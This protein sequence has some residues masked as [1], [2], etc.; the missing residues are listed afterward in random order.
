M[1]CTSYFKRFYCPTSSHWS[2]YFYFWKS[3]RHDY[4]FLPT[5][6]LELKSENKMDQ[7]VISKPVLTLSQ[8]TNSMLKI[9]SPDWENPHIW[10]NLLVCYHDYKSLPQSLSRAKW[11]K[12]KTPN[13]IVLRSILLLPSR[14]CLG[15]PVCTFL[16]LDSCHMHCPFHLPWLDY[17]NMR[18]AVQIIMFLTMQPSSASFMSSKCDI[19]KHFNC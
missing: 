11:I 10:Q 12:F 7:N 8:T 1:W 19:L 3:R 13:L 2:T 18:Q 16:H 4:V 5:R 9:P 15:L 17:T 14:L 6:V